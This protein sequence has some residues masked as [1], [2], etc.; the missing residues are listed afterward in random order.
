MNYYFTEPREDELY[1]YGVKGM[2]WGVRKQ[3]SLKGNLHRLAAANYGLNERTYRKLGN[4]SLASMNAQAKNNSLKK[5]Q[6][7]DAAKAQR[8]QSKAQ[9][10]ASAQRGKI[11][12]KKSLKGSMARTMSHVYALNESTYR[13]LGNKTLASMNASA[14]TQYQNKANAYDEARRQRIRNRKGL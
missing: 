7:A 10:K 5:A 6:A 9:H 14:K 1:H 12:A 4:N 2:R 8:R 3:R 13:K 11:A